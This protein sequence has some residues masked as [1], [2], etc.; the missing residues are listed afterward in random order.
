[1]GPFDAAHAPAALA[2]ML[3]DLGADAAVTFT[4]VPP[5][6]TVPQ[7]A[8]VLGTSRA[9]VSRLVDDGVLPSDFHGLHRRVARADVVALARRRAAT[10]T[11]VLD[12]LADLAVELYEGDLLDAATLSSAVRGCQQLYHVAA[13]YSTRPEDAAAMYRVNVDGT[14]ALLQ[15]AAES[16]VQTIVHTSTIGTIGR[17][18]DGRLPTEEDQFTEVSRASPYALSKLQGERLALDLAARGARVVVV[19]PCAP[20]GA[21]DLKPSSTGARVLAYL[22]G[23][24]PSFLAGGIN[25]VAVEDVAAGHLLAAERGGSGQRYILGNAAGNLTLEG[26]CALMEAVT[27]IAP[28]RAAARPAIQHA[29]SG[30]VLIG[31]MR[32]ALTPQRGAPRDQR[33]AALTADPSRAIR[34]LGLPQ[35][36][37]EQAFREAVDW[38]RAHGYPIA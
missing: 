2:R 7:A 34:E 25:F 26:F 19:N 18:P 11:Q 17:P 21:R 38:Y 14:R 27:G 22:Q 4:A 36:P 31:R 1:M 13:L 20:V 15:A 35:T 8:D 3:D 12:N 24:T 30:R 16:G 9:D 23:R 5:L 37:L 33:P 32:R 28:P 29:L 10:R 6:L